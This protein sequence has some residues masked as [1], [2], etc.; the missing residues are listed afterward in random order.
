M[1]QLLTV[2]DTLVQSPCYERCG[3]P[4]A[5]SVAEAIPNELEFGVGRVEDGGDG[6][7]KL[8]LHGLEYTMTVEEAD[9]FKKSPST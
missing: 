7:R 1:V 2:H 3:R 4:L 9:N 8:G 6:G 5:R